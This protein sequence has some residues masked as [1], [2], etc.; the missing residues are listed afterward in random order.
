MK[1]TLTSAQYKLRAVFNLRRLRASGMTASMNPTTTSDWRKEAALGWPH[2]S[3][4]ALL[5]LIIAAGIWGWL[6][7]RPDVAIP[8]HLRDLMFIILGHY[9]A[10]RSRSEPAGG[11]PPLYLPRGA[12]R[13]L[14]MLGFLCTGVVLFR[15]ARLG[16][17]TAPNSAAVTLVLVAGFMIGVLVNHLPV[18][19]VPRWLEDLRALA[20]L[21]AGGMLLLLV[22]GLLAAPRLG[23][24]QFL[25]DHSV[26]ELLAAVVGFYFGSRS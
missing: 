3:V 6:L 10:A 4:R 12:V 7:Y 5:A 20:S 15:Q 18:R 16:S 11:P 25:L 13:M 2:G 14:L 22:F 23:I 21:A 24:E 1:P 26:E 8:S 19:R 9:F 17:L